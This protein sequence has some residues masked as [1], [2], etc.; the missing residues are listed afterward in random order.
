MIN[1]GAVRGFS[2][3]SVEDVAD[4]KQQ[5]CTDHSSLTQ[6]CMGLPK[7]RPSLE[8]LIQNVMI[9]FKKSAEK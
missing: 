8:T 3:Q 6:W 1:S 9:F 7:M 4:V 2:I 5:L